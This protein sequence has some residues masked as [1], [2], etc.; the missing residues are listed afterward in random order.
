M[1]SPFPVADR[2]RGVA[3]RRVLRVGASATIAGISVPNVD[4]ILIRGSHEL[5]A[6]QNADNLI[7][8]WKLNS[9]FLTGTMK[10][11]ITSPL[12]ESPT[13]I[14]RFGSRL[15]VANAKVDAGFPPTATRFEVNVVRP[16][17]Q[18]L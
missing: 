3:D 15:A 1:G 18:A 5:F 13:T 16:E 14:A 12:F 11:V 10:K 6:A 17:R 2:C 4:G 8:V 7:S 9:D